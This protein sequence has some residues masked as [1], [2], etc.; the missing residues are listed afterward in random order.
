L[1]FPFVL[2]LLQLSSVHLPPT[3]SQK[4]ADLCLMCAGKPEQSSQEHSIAQIAPYWKHAFT[5]LHTLR[6]L[7]KL[8]II[9]FIMYAWR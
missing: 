2:C 5:K 7:D 1:L 9:M 3:D 8:A 6:C 4:Q